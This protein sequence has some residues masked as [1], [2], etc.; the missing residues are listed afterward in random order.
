MKL[1]TVAANGYGSF[2]G[3]GGHAKRSQFPTAPGGTGPQGTGPMMQNEA[4]LLWADRQWT[5]GG[6]V[7]PAG[8]AGPERAKRTQFGGVKYAKRT[9]LWPLRRSGRPIIPPFH[10]SGIPVPRLQGRGQSCETKP[11]P[12]RAG[13]GEA[14]GTGG[15]GCCTNKAN[16]PR[17]DWK[18]RWAGAGNAAAD[19]HKRAKRS[20]SSP[21]ADTMDLQYATVCRPHGGAPGGRNSLVF[22]IDTCG[23]G[24]YTRALYLPQDRRYRTSADGGAKLS[25]AIGSNRQTD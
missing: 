20:Q 8:A 6:K 5:R 12:G 15:V 13:W 23:G 17:T 22:G 3:L 9:Q 16:L 7:A 14:G 2:G 11:I 24:D 21:R 18:R 25:G 4:N 1:T 19:G 10:P